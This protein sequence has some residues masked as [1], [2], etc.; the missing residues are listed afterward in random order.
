MMRASNSWIRT[1]KDEGASVIT[2]PLATAAK[3]PLSN[4]SSKQPS[5]N[6]SMINPT[7][8]NTNTNNSGNPNKQRR[9]SLHAA[10]GSLLGGLDKDDKENQHLRHSSSMNNNHAKNGSWRRHSSASIW[11]DSTR[12]TPRSSLVVELPSSAAAGTTLSARNHPA[13]VNISDDQTKKKAA[14]ATTTTT[15]LPHQEE[16]PA[17][18]SSSSSWA[19]ISTYRAPSSTAASTTRESSAIIQ[20]GKN[21]WMSFL[22]DDRDPS[23]SSSS[24]GELS[25]SELSNGISP[26]T[27]TTTTTSNTMDYYKNTAVYSPMGRMVIQRTSTSGSPLSDASVYNTTPTSTTIQEQQVLLGDGD[28]QNEDKAKKNSDAASP[29]SNVDDDDDSPRR[30]QQQHHHPG[31]APPADMLS[32]GVQAARL[33]FE[34]QSQKALEQQ[35]IVRGNG[36]AAAAA[37]T[38]MIPNSSKSQDEQQNKGLPQNTVTTVVSTAT[39]KRTST[40]AGRGALGIQS[41]REATT[42]S[43]SSSSLRLVSMYHHQQQSDSILMNANHRNASSSPPDAM[44]EIGGPRRSSTGSTSLHSVVLSPPTTGTT[45]TDD[46]RSSFQQAYRAWQRVGLM[47]LNNNNNNNKTPKKFGF[48]SSGSLGTENA[49]DTESPVLALH[50]TTPPANW[51]NRTTAVNTPQT[52]PAKTA[53]PVVRTAPPLAH[54]QKDK[55]DHAEEKNNNDESDTITS[56]FGNILSAWRNKSDDRPN[57]HFLSPGTSSSKRLPS[58][59]PNTT[60]KL[61]TTTATATTNKNRRTS[62]QGST[63]T[64]TSSIAQKIQA[65][66]KDT[67]ARM[68]DELLAKETNQKSTQEHFKNDSC[69]ASVAANVVDSDF[70][71]KSFV[72]ESGG[73]SNRTLVSLENKELV[74]LSPYNQEL[75][76]LNDCT[77]CECSGS[78][79]SGN[80]ELTS[81]FL[82]QMG[83]ACTC[84]KKKPQTFVN[85]DDPTA[86]ENVLRPWQV[87]FLKSFGI[88]RGEQLVKARH[89]SAGILSSALRQWR[90]KQGM[91]PFKTSSCGMAI[92]IWAKTCK[93]YVRSIRRQIQHAGYDDTNH[94]H[95]QQQLE[96]RSDDVMKEL[97]HFVGDLPAAPQQRMLEITSSSSIA[98]EPKSEMEV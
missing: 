80:D 12:N 8:T 49:E 47:P 84:G 2:S 83:M 1:P 85:P 17:A 79:F 56:Q 24:P 20:H 27:I 66:E 6:G 68:R 45:T 61:P 86:L 75:N 44:I 94:H 55:S 22:E 26:A 21:F 95:H 31:V 25:C 92:D 34:Q 96:R 9:R 53:P 72:E 62:L 90:R 18:A 37:G 73:D 23:L 32:P 42:S 60:S 43:S 51:A 87:E 97:T 54:L 52:V 30:D 10:A 14:A 41:I 78:I 46:D 16:S 88:F 11:K 89:R 81:F 7:N 82:P 35:A 3:M 69:K 29:S 74:P 64:A 39:S 59:R 63:S 5:N 15:N 48:S 40:S 33:R 65:F 57:S 50:V 71:E 58:A 98:I 19:R 77:Q 38:A 70:F 91:V 13:D 76:P 93:I 36:G 4:N 28:N 67:F